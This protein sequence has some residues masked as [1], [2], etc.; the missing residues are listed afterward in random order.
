MQ[1]YKDVELFE[2]LLRSI[3][4][5]Q[6]YYCIHVDHSSPPSVHAV[7]RAIVNCFPNVF[8]PLLLVD[9]V[10]YEM[11]VLEADLICM[12]ELLNKYKNWK[13]YINLT[14]QEFPL[15][16]NLEIVRILQF[17]NGANNIHRSNVNFSE[18]YVHC[19]YCW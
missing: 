10:S 8:M 1:V 12:E 5:P 9:V 7:V 4:R 14:G 13:Y 15:R 17:F 2:R 19:S 3:Y 16:T 18:R 11:S 6:N